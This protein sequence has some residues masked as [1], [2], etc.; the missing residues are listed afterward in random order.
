[1]IVERVI[2][3]LQRLLGTSQIVTRI[4]EWKQTYA[5]ALVRC[6]FGKSIEEE[7]ATIVADG[8]RERNRWVYLHHLRILRDKVDSF[9]APAGM[10]S[11]LRACLEKAAGEKPDSKSFDPEAVTRPLVEG[12]RAFLAELRHAHEQPLFEALDS[13]IESYR[14]GRNYE[15]F[16]KTRALRGRV[17]AMIENAGFDVQRDYLCRL[18]GLLEEMGY[19]ALRHVASRYQDTGVDLAECLHIVRSCTLNLRYDGLFS[20]ELIDFAEMLTDPS[21]TDDELLN[22]L[23]NIERVYHRVRQRVTVPYEKMQ[24]RLGLDDNELRGRR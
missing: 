17:V 14:A 19:L 10:G 3:D 11:E 18:E 23:E 5:E 9:R 13:V 2:E 22:V 16:D 1:M 20:R 4:E 12:V 15:V 8:I 6:E 21:R 24:Q 7:L